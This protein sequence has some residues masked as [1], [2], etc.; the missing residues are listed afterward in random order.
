MNL[1]PG[2]LSD[3][4]SDGRPARA[5]YDV[6]ILRPRKLPPCRTKNF[7]LTPLGSVL[8]LPPGAV[9]PV[10]KAPSFAKNRYRCQ[11]YQITFSASWICREVVDV[12]STAP[13]APTGFPFASKN[14]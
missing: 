4:A 2:D 1:S 3:S 6:L 12:L 8:G 5:V 10:T 9:K 11:G 13:A 7:V 14:V